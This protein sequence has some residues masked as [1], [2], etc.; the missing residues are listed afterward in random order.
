MKSQVHHTLHCNLE[1][2]ISLFYSKMSTKNVQLKPGTPFGIFLG[3][4]FQIHIG[5]RAYRKRL[6]GEAFKKNLKGDLISRSRYLEAQVHFFLLVFVCG[7]Y[8]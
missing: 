7:F 4:Y 1:V 2:P 6:K 3:I 5:E 8:D